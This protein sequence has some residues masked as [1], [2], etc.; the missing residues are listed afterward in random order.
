MSDEVYLSAEE[1]KSYVGRGFGRGLFKVVRDKYGDSL[2]YRLSDLDN[3]IA[4]R[5]SGAKIEEKITIGLH[6]KPYEY[7]DI[8]SFCKL[9]KMS[10]RGLVLRVVS[11]ANESPEFLKLLKED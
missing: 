11:K 2:G 6:C 3:F 4:K 10:Y 8:K 1:A 7:Q 5:E 9:H